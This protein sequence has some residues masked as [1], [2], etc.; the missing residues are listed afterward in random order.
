MPATSQAVIV[1]LVDTLQALAGSHPGFR[2]AHAKGIVGAGTFHPSADARRVT[3]AAHLQGPAVPV[4]VRFS[5]SSGNPEVPDGAPGVRAMAV[6]FPLAGGKS[7]DILANS[8]DGFVARTPEEFLEFLRAQLPDP[9]TGKPSPDAVPKFLG[10]HPASAAFVGRLMQKPVPASYAQAGYHGEH[11]FLFTAADGS[12]RHGRYHFTPDAGEVFLTA[13]DGG[14][15]SANFLR[16]ELETRLQGGPVAFRLMLQI[17]AEGDPTDDPTALWPA[18]RPRVDLGRLEITS[19]SP[20]S[21]QDERRLIFDPT[22]RTDGIDLSNDPILLAR[23][24]A[25]AVS[26]ERRTRGQ[27]S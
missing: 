3:K 24:A 27:T 16:D 5:N 2:P 1:Q 13:E 25:Y 9:A 20:T 17:A 19:L 22:N 14:K 11:A 21:A 15:R 8:I 23:S 4:V 10:S 7:A 6:K 18:D 26:Y 12:R